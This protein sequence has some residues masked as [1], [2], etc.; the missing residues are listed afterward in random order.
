MVGTFDVGMGRFAKRKKKDIFSLS[1]LFKRYSNT[2]QLVLEEI[3]P[4]AKSDRYTRDGK[5]RK[6]SAKPTTGDN[7]V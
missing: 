6:R 4:P 5:K 2:T 3:K 1:K 7:Y